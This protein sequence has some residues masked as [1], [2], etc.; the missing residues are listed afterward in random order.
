L[1]KS[2]DLPGDIKNL[3]IADDGSVQLGRGGELVEFGFRVMNVPFTASTRHFDSGP[4][5]Q[6]S[7]KV[8]SLPYSVESV[9]ARHNALAIIE[10]SKKL[11]FSRLVLT[12]DKFIYCIGRTPV[13]YPWSPTDLISAGADIVLEIQPYLRLLAEILPAW[14]HAAKPK[15]TVDQGAVN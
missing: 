3:Q 10:A 7:G 12:K 8:A 4:M 14:P 1:L 2:S 13:H 5:L 11:S 6:V 9:P 15:I